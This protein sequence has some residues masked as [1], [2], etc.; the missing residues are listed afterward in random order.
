MSNIVQI[1]GEPIEP[2][3]YNGQRVITFEMIDRVHGRPDGTASRN[4]RTHKDKFINGEDYYQIQVDEIRRAGLPIKANNY[5]ITLLTESGYLMVCKSLTDDRSW[6]VQRSLVKTYFRA[7]ELVEAT[8]DHNLWVKQMMERLAIIGE[9]HEKKIDGLCQEISTVGEKVDTF[10]Y[11]F[12]ER[13][14]GIETL[15]N[16]G[17]KSFHAKLKERGGTVCIEHFSSKCPCCGDTLLF[18][19]GV[20][21]KFLNYDHWNEKPQDNR[22]TNFWVICS[23][24]NQDFKNGKLNRAEQRYKFNFFQERLRKLD[25]ASKQKELFKVK[26]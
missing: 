14:N 5:G 22:A 16:S 6:E 9:S 25:P 10:S 15:L 3:E 24:C 23:Q 1:H 8:Q 4:F 21:T 7:K 13:L 19:N 20:K 2:L 26:N 11:T 12:D 18:H 17:R